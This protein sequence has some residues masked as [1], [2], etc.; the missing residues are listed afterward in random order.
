MTIKSDILA[1]DGGRGQT[2][3]CF[4]EPSYDIDGFILREG[5]PIVQ[6]TDMVVGIVNGGAWQIVRRRQSPGIFPSLLDDVDVPQAN[7]CR[8]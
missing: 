2:G 5:R 6:H 4:T 1:V 7:R 3:R 8:R